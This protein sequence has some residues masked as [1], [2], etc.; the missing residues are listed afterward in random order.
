MSLRLRR[1]IVASRTAGGRIALSLTVAA[2][3]AVAASP[4]AGGV[5]VRAAI[6]PGSAA[7]APGRRMSLAQA[8]AGLRAAVRR[9]PGARAVTPDDP[10]QQAKLT[11]SGGAEGNDFGTSVAISG[12]T[13]V[14]GA[15]DSPIGAAY[16]FVRSGGVWSQEAELTPSDGVIG[17][18]FGYSVAISGSTVVVG[19]FDA[20][21]GF[22]AAYVYERSGTTWSQQAELSP[23]DGDGFGFSV[24]ISGSTI[25]VG[26]SAE[27][28]YAGVVY[29]FVRSGT[30]WTQQA[31]LTA[32]DGVPGDEFG[33]SVAVS[34]STVVVGAAYA[35]AN[36]GSAY[37]FARAGTVWSQQ[38]EL[39]PSEPVAGEEFGRSV[40]ISRATAVV[41]APA[42]DSGT[43]AVYVFARSG[44][45]WSQQAQLVDT[46]DVRHAYL[47]HSVAISG[48]TVVASAPVENEIAG[49]AYVFTRSGTT[50]SQLAELTASDGGYD[51]ELGYAAAV[52]GK[53]AMF[54]APDDN[55]DTGAAY[56]FAGL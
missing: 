23:S 31:E 55:F 35:N 9:T 36:T 3:V 28:S 54:G 21:S 12:S 30:E 49:A 51:D 20:R 4:P 10:F 5:I 34:G 6:H 15:P 13:A 53:T 22:G 43:G 27:D 47:G 44:T 11:A 29:V 40:A 14:V 24:A 52:S 33:Q 37:V 19:A 2:V 18:F 50:W 38:A 17:D 41:G 1:L 56:V 25:A 7:S 32:S 8:P 48:H 45:S 16:V 26:A 46:E 39:M 42:R